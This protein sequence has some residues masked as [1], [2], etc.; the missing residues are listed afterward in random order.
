MLIEHLLD[1][2]VTC[3]T[4]RLVLPDGGVHTF[5]GDKPGREITMR[6][7]DAATARQLFFKPRLHLGEAYMDG[8]LTVDGE[9]IRA[10]R[11]SSITIRASSIGGAP[12]PSMTRAFSRTSERA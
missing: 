6:L 3:G 8:R 12:L 11:P 4:L 7:H 9:P 2:L 10:I 1:H 5:T